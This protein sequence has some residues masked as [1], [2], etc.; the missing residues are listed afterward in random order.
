MFRALGNPVRVEILHWLRDPERHFGMYPPT[1]D[2]T[3]VGVCATHIQAKSGLAQSTT[4]ANL[5]MLERA[6]LLTATRIGKFIHYRR[7]EERIA[8]FVEAL[9]REL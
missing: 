5:T 7:N 4:S 9:G 6:G 3:Q 8:A 1:A 2:R